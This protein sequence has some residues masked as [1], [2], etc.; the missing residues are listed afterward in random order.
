MTANRV[1]ALRELEK[2]WRSMAGLGPD[3]FT[4]AT[5][6]DCADELA[7]LLSDDRQ[8]VAPVAG[9][10]DAVRMLL[11]SA[12]AHMTPRNAKEREAYKLLR[13]I[14]KEAT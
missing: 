8:E 7:A 3:T 11:D 13:S 10:T 2:K 4:G 5:L 12:P 6:G 9:L 1:D 14:M